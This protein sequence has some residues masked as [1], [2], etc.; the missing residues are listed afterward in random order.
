ME[1]IYYDVAPIEYGWSAKGQEGEAINF[2]SKEAAISV[3]A[4]VAKKVWEESGRPSGVRV[5]G[6]DGQ[7]EEE[8]TYGEL[9]G[10]VTSASD[11]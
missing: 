1:R 7:W 4:A 2:G 8:R 3:A 11:P 9:D 5:L 10:Q 6:P